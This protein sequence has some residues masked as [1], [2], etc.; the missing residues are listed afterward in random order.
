MASVSK[1][2]EDIKNPKSETSSDMLNESVQ[3][4][5]LAAAI[6]AGV[7]LS[8][9]YFRRY[10]LFTSALVGMIGGALISNLLISKK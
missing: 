4:N 1:M 9:G 3:S 10:N 2:I 5:I 7:G 8:V 6:G